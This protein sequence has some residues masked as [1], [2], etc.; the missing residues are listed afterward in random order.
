MSGLRGLLSA[1]EIPKYSPTS[2]NQFFFGCSAPLGA[3]SVALPA[4]VCRCDTRCARSSYAVY[5]SKRSLC[6]RAMAKATTRFEQVMECSR[7]ILT[8]SGSASGSREC[9]QRTRPRFCE[10]RMICVQYLRPSA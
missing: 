10:A 8:F 3:T 7:C 2:L 5:G 1:K 6:F 4:K 9:T